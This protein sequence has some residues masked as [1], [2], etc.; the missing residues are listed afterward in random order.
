MVT[1]WH[2]KARD[3][4]KDTDYACETSKRMPNQS[5]RWYLD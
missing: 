3:K 1:Y 4:P 5:S 2:I